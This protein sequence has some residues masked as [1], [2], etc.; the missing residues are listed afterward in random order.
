MIFHV[1]FHDF[2]DFS[3]VLSTLFGRNPLKMDTNIIDLPE[4]ASY[5]RGHSSMTA[6]RFFMSRH[7]LKRARGDL[8]LCADVIP[9]EFS[10]R[11]S[12][13]A[14]ENAFFRFGPIPRCA[15]AY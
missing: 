2:L 7:A 13:L 6:E 8:A 10:A 12:K 3:L 15:P 14:R 9:R 5:L 11:T 4:I 1:F